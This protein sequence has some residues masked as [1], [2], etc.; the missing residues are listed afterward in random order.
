MKKFIYKPRE[1]WSIHENAH[2]SIVDKHDFELA[3]E[4]MAMD[5]RT[6]QNKTCLHLFSGFLLCGLCSQPMTAKTTTKKNGKKYINY[7]C[8]THKKTGE[9]QNNNISEL[10][11][12]KLVLSAIKQQVK[13]FTI[14]D[15]VADGLTHAALRSRKQASIESMIERNLQSIKDNSDYL[16]K[17]YEHFADE[18]ISESEYQ[19]FKKSFNSQIE[20]AEG[21]IAALKGELSR[22]E[23]DTTAKRLI[24]RFLEHGNIEEINRRIV[25]GLIK[26][27]NVNTN[28]DVAVNF[29]YSHYYGISSDFGLVTEIPSEPY[30]TEKAVV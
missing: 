19:M 16:V 7:I 2:E 21:N 10:S 30:E 26:S 23:D 18:V 14:S 20:T 1:A 28:K 11:L 12:N 15:K 17:S 13:C 9:C 6:G 29:R 24:E 27:I 25:A 22:L 3:Q 5:T 8:S 4:L